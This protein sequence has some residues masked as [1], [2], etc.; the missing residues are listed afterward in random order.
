MQFKL[1]ENLPVELAD[2]LSASGHDAL[3]VADQ[4]LRGKDD[5]M[6][7]TVCQAETRALITTDLDFSDIRMYPP[8]NTS[9]IVVLRPRRQSKT[10][11]LALVTRI[12]PLLE[13]E[14]L[15]GTLWVVDEAE[16]RIR[17]GVE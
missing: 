11:V 13:K 1:D 7:A 3:T 4:G 2:L 15:A 16:V 8:R 10:R 6:L 5:N 14:T 17:G 9:G 12:L